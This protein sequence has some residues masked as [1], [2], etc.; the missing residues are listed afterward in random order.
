MRCASARK[1]ISE[2]LDEAPRADRAAKLKDHLAACPDCLRFADDFESIVREAGRLP[3]LEPSGEVWTKIVAGLR[4]SRS[5]APAAPR[6]A[7]RRRLALAAACSVIVLA[8]GVVIG[9]RDRTGAA[10]AKRGSVEFAMAKLK[11]AQAYYEKA[12]GALSEA[13]R[14]REKDIAPGLAEVFERNLEGLDQSIRVCRQMVN[15]SPDDPT[16][17]TCLLTAYREKVNLFEDV[18]GLGPASGG[19]TKTTTL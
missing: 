13:V 17:R 14:A 12:I 18:M 16:A 4:T 1:L 10:A 9:L 19:R 11:E 7:G 5:A 2:S 3:V 6:F 15:K 8:A